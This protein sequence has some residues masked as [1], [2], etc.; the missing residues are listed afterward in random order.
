MP[1]STGATGVTG[2]TGAT[3]RAGPPAARRSDRRDGSLGVDRPT[4]I[5]RDGRDRQPRVRRID[6]ANVRA[7]PQEHK[8]LQGLD[9][10]DRRDRVRRVDR[11]SRESRRD[12]RHRQPSGAPE[13]T[14]NQRRHERPLR[15]AKARRC[16]GPTGADR[17]DR[18]QGVDG[19][20]G[21]G[22]RRD[23]AG[24]GSH[25]RAGHRGIQG[26]TGATGPRV[27]RIDWDNGVRAS[28][29]PRRVHR[30]QPALPGPRAR[31]VTG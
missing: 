10:P 16:D 4:G 22:V 23:R 15:V 8:A 25:R 20:T 6:W 31:R 13:S 2:T 9:G 28:P 19:S 30:V 24:H 1:G 5:G 12:G 29:R 7:A 27:E 18:V 17:P 11:P 21:D 26:A 3:G 14:G